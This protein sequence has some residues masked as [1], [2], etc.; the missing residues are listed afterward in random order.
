VRGAG[1]PPIVTSALAS[2]VSRTPDAHR[3]SQNG[4]LVVNADDWGRDPETTRCIL[5]CVRRGT[6]TAASAMVFMETSD[7]AAALA[8]EHSL[9]AGLHL[10]FTDSFTSAAC[11]SE[12]RERQGVISAYLRRHRWAQLVFNPTLWSAFEYVV[13]TQI[14][15]YQRLYGTVPARLDG[16][17]HMH[18]CTN[19]L[20]GGLLPQGTHIRRIFSFRSGE[21][22]VWNR[23]YRR[24][25]DSMLA[26][27]HD[28]ADYLFSLAP[29]DMARL[30]RI[31]DL[32]RHS[33]VELETHPARAEEYRFLMSDE[34][35]KYAQGIRLGPFAVVAKRQT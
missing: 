12:L 21:K 31:L 23:L 27:R 33:V 20:L 14:D 35:H 24:A 17:H 18:L 10:N 8:R 11:S 13:S 32:A 7:Q 29:L 1:G 22:S 6:V 5:D 30:Q 2:E 15:E 16:H 34:L 3:G 25:S 9:D 19:V 4:L 28:V 26:R